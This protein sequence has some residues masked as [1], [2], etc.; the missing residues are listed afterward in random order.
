MRERIICPE[1]EN[2]FH[3]EIEEARTQ[4]TC[5]RCS[6]SFA[7][8]S[9]GA[10]L[11]NEDETVSVRL[12][13]SDDPDDSGDALPGDRPGKI[14]DDPAPGMI[15]GNYEIINEIAR[16]AT[17]IVYKARQKNL[18]RIVALK[19]LIAGETASE[20]QIKRFHQEARAVAKLRH[21][22]I[23]PVYELGRRADGTL[24]YTMKVV[25]DTRTL[26]V[27]LSGLRAGD[28][29]VSRE[30]PTVRLLDLFQHAC[31]GLSFAHV[32]GVVHRVDTG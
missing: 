18:D 29:E 2:V 31:M 9:N 16:G 10:D 21:P 3:L 8:I 25:R 5:S 19:V 7:H 20:E 17:G 4:I 14:E 30:Y 22:N 13:K 24:Y 12:L 6:H 32:R 23:V 26:D 15:F 27:V 1:C 28:P 11:D